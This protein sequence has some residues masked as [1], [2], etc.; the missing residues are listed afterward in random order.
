VKIPDNALIY[1]D[2]PYS[3]TNCGKYD[4]FD[5]EVFYKWA[6][7]Q[8]NIFISEYKMPEPFIEI[9]STQKSILSSPKGNCGKATEEIFTNPRTYARYDG[10]VCDKQL[11]FFDL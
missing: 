8:D 7:E 10:A 2:I 1:C 6:I 9:A 11:N 5:H 3:D 4:G